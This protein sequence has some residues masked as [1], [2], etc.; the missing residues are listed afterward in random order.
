MAGFQREFA[1]FDKGGNSNI[2]AQEYENELM[3]SC[4]LLSFAGLTRKRVLRQ[5][6]KRTVAFTAFETP[7][8]MNFP[9]PRPL[10]LPPPDHHPPPARE[11][12]K[13]WNLTFLFQ[14]QLQHSDVNPLRR[15]IIPKKAAE[16]FLP[17]L[18]TKD[19]MSIIMR[20][21]DGLHSWT[22]KFRYWPNN[23]SR[24]YVL[25]NTGDFVNVH[26]LKQGDYVLVYRDENRLYV[27]QAKKAADLEAEATD[28]TINDLSLSDFEVITS[29][30]MY[31]TFPLVDDS[32]NSYVYETSFTTDSSP[33]GFFDNPVSNSSPKIDPLESFGSVESWLFND[34]QFQ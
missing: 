7:S 27:I 23:N 30:D 12:M 2:N 29:D 19:G 13:H 31:V 26:G 33:F 3:M 4:D 17:V 10:F 1:N 20:D 16:T 11:T 21:F 28:N 15:M 14:K 5:A 25:E 18:E 6:R 22:F 9:P 34:L 32:H 8:L 24:M